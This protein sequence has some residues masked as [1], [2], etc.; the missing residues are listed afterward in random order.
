MLRVLLRWGVMRQVQQAEPRVTFS[1]LTSTAAGL[2][3]G[4]LVAPGERADGIHVLP[5]AD[6]KQAFKRDH[7]F[8]IKLNTIIEKL[9]LFQMNHGSLLFCLTVT[10]LKKK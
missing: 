4:R 8:L 1:T 5:E 3:V 2:A 9:T 7:T 10:Q 6:G